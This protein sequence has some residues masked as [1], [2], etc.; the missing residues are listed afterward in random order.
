MYIS[1]GR[2]SPRVIAIR[3]LNR[4]IASKPITLAASAID[5]SRR[6]FFLPWIEEEGKRLVP[7]LDN[8]KGKS[9]E[10]AR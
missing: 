7:T 5:I 9:N 4:S 8:L 3:D 6:V 10:Q 1:T 2:I